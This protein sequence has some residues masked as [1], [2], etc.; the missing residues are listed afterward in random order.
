MWQRPAHCEQNGAV[1]VSGMCSQHSLL[2]GI[3]TMD[4][5]VIMRDVSQLT[6]DDVFVA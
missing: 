3:E 4:F 5:N 1:S 6:G 2:A